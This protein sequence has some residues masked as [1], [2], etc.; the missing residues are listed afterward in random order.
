LFGTDSPWR[1]QGWSTQSVKEL[2]LEPEIE[3]AIFYKNAMELL[4][5]SDE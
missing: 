5:L 2:C 3:E 1:D 4:G